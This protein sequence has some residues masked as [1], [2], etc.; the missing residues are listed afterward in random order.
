MADFDG[1]WF[2]GNTRGD[3]RRVR[4]KDYYKFHSKAEGYSAPELVIY[5]DEVGVVDKIIDII[6][7]SAGED[8][9]I[10]ETPVG[11]EEEK[12][13]YQ[14]GSDW[15]SLTVIVALGMMVLISRRIKKKGQSE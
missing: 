7:P 13:W 14:I 3:W 9:E 2:I 8:D 4:A 15:L 6:D 1:W 12:P 5:H 11:V 10:T